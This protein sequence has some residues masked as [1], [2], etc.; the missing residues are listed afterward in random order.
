MAAD[1]PRSDAPDSDMPGLLPDDVPPHD[2]LD[3]RANALADLLSG[4]GDVPHLMRVLHEPEAAPPGVDAPEPDMLPSSP[5]SAIHPPDVP[6]VAEARHRPDRFDATLGFPGEG[7]TW[8]LATYDLSQEHASPPQTMAEVDADIAAFEHFWQGMLAVGRPT[9]HMDELR[10]IR[11]AMLAR[12]AYDSLDHEQRQLCDDML[13]KL[14]RIFYVLHACLRDYLGSLEDDSASDGQPAPDPLDH[15]SNCIGDA[16]SVTPDV[17]TTDGH[18]D[19]IPERHPEPEP[20]GVDGSADDV[21]AGSA[22]DSVASD[23]HAG[24]ALDEQYDPELAEDGAQAWTSVHTLP[25]GTTLVDITSSES[26]MGTPS[27]GPAT[28]VATLVASVPKKKEKRKHSLSDDPF[29][30]VLS[31]LLT[32]VERSVSDGHAVTET[33]R[34]TVV[35]LQALLLPAEL[36]DVPR[37]FGLRAA[38]YRDATLPDQQLRDLDVGD[39][40]DSQVRVAWTDCLAKEMFVMCKVTVYDLARWYPPMDISRLET[41]R[42]L[43]SADAGSPTRERTL[44][45]LALCDDAYTKSGVRL[46]KTRAEIAVKGV[47]PLDINSNVW[48]C[49]AQHLDEIKGLA[50]FNIDPVTEAICS[51]FLRLLNTIQADDTDQRLQLLIRV[52]NDVD[53]NPR[54]SHQLQSALALQH[55]G[56]DLPG[57][58]VVRVVSTK[59]GRVYTNPHSVY[60]FSTGQA[61]SDS[62]QTSSAPASIPPAPGNQTVRLPPPPRAHPDN[63]TRRNRGSGGR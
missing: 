14:P 3:P 2:R 12:D 10:R 34:Q 53:A 41:A 46:C 52:E 30:R 16:T 20:S 5:V 7:P 13:D 25:R 51:G 55:H 22:P 45:I 32:Q 4:R 15:D 11:T 17:A 21:A 42:R 58:R 29:E 60:M 33:L 9:R 54:T 8:P 63:A 27:T 44:E 62:A 57:S 35:T 40:W 24:V 47:D 49:H 36:L 50:R 39:A 6:L 37:Y 18:V 23:D 31:S 59:R 19:T 28:P 56:R 38:R 43:L 61:A 48:L 1:R 26:A